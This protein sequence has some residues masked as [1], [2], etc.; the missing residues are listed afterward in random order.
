V[1]FQR[2]SYPPAHIDFSLCSVLLSGP[3]PVATV[4]GTLVE[5]ERGQEYTN[6]HGQVIKMGLCTIVRRNNR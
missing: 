5:P 3:A 2:V 6:A 1:R 4:F